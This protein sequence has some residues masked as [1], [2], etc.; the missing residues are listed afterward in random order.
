MTNNNVIALRK[1]KRTAFLVY[2]GYSHL[3]KNHL[4]TETSNRIN[5]VE[6]V[7]SDTIDKVKQLIDKDEVD[8]FI[9][10]GSNAQL[11]R[12]HFPTQA[13]VT[14]GVNEFDIL[15]SLIQA[16][17]IG[18]SA[19]IITYEEYI[20]ELNQF[21]SLLKL[22]LSQEVFSSKQ[23][24]E[25]I[26]AKLKSANEKTIIGSSVV[27][28]YGSKH[29][30]NTIFIYSKPSI[31]KAISTALELQ[32][33]IQLEKKK[34][35][36]LK[37][38]TDYTYSGVISIDENKIIQ[39]C[40]PAAEN[41]LKIKKEDV[42]KKKI[43]EVIPNT[44]L[45]EV[46]ESGKLQLNK[47]LTINKNTTIFTNR[48]PIVVDG[49]TM[50]AVATFHDIKDVQNAEH[51]IRK[52][53]SQKQLVARYDLDDILGNSYSIQ[54][55]RR[56]AKIYANTDETVLLFGE[57]GTGKELFA[58]GIHNYSPRKDYP[59]VAVNCAALPENLLESELFGYEKGAFTGADK[60]GKTGLIELAHGGTLYLDEVSE[61][62][63]RL[64]VYLLRFLQEREIL[65]VGGRKIV[66]VNVRIIASSNK[67]LWREVEK[68]NFRE[69]LYY[70][71]NLLFL[72]I[73]ALKERKEDIP[74]LVRNFVCNHSPN[75]YGENKNL[76]NKLINN[77][78][79]YDWPGNIRE[80][81]NIV[82][83]YCIILEQ[84]YSVAYDHMRL[85]IE[86]IDSIS[87]SEQDCYSNS[88][89]K[90]EKE[91]VTKNNSFEFTET[92]NSNPENENQLKELA[93][94][95]RYLRSSNVDLNSEK[96]R[97]LEVLQKTGGNRDKAAQ[98]LGIS[99]TTL[100][101]KMKKLDL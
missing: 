75:L 91:S 40:N 62:P 14:M 71:L 28:D 72:K 58:Q 57:T 16:S 45:V 47:L 59:F 27:C 4:D 22:E 3:I 63:L 7:F 64:Q 5:F 6:C 99:R 83:R 32:N 15:R 33:S 35:Q 90:S 26:L 70:R 84:E 69:D 95:P 18:S 17:K 54:D 44:R 38:L 96:N 34:S 1:N 43:E 87:T 21:N 36:L 73:P 67:D 77:F 78:I 9:T 24:L 48:V 41:I 97:I 11:L 56:L 76:W 81:E 52:E 50:G 19:T 92:K 20:K 94:I 66:P 68:G 55:A 74:V 12:K 86:K 93:K 65:R 85:D 8:V 10:G 51:Q 30:F 53:L 100:W 25:E 37:T 80:L 61:I 89:E 13:L 23:E 39:A 60:E 29:G 42:L 101:R 49:K 2:P 79:K 46:L 31:Q 88:L 82:T 98:I